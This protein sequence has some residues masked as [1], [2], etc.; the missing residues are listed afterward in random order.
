MPDIYKQAQSFRAALVRR[1]TAAVELLTNEYKAVYARL[2]RLLAVVN[3]QI[4]EASRNGQTV[5]RHWLNQQERYQSFLRQLD[6]EFKSYGR[7]VSQVV[8]ARQLFEANQGVADSAAMIGGSF[9][10]LPVGA[11]QEIVAN[12]QFDSPLGQLLQRFGDV[13]ARNAAGALRD[14]VAL[15][16]NPRKSARQVRDALGIPL[17]RALLISRTESARA[18][19]ES[20]RQN[21]LVNKDR[22]PQWMW[23][24]AKSPRTCLN[25][26]SR[27]GDIYSV[28]KPLPAHPACRCVMIPLIKDMTLPRKE[29]AEQWFLKQ[30]DA[31]KRQ[32]MSGIAFDALKAGK[33]KL[34]D[35]EGE[36]RSRKWGAYTYER[37]MREIMAER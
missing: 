3:S 17:S 35:F 34:K 18:Y 6:L 27:D 19:R 1:D 21:M 28:T 36:G 2:L 24:A 23:V 7:F 12:L 20:A 33:V 5:S 10:R 13:A 29:T 31:V 15:G 8:Y 16:W 32:M 14:A 26:L 11:V 4:A 9:N 22:V 30:H 25:C 37:S